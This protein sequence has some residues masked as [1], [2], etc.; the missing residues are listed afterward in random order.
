MTIIQVF[1]S[2]KTLEE[3]KLLSTE[4]LQAN[5]I[6]AKSE[7]FQNHTDSF[8]I[9]DI[10]HVLQVT[11]SGVIA[12]VQVIQLILNLQDRKNNSQK[13][14]VAI[15]IKASNGKS[16]DLKAS[17]DLTD[18]ETKKYLNDI[19]SFVDDFL[20]G[21]DGV[22]LRMPSEGGLLSV[23]VC[24]ANQLFRELDDKLS[25]IRELKCSY[26]RISDSSVVAKLTFAQ[27]SLIEFIMG[28]KEKK[29][30]LNYS[31]AIECQDIF[32][33]LER[34]NVLAFQEISYDCKAD[35]DDLSITLVRYEVNQSPLFEQLMRCEDFVFS[36]L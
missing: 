28:S 32:Y 26:H 11:F 5:E 19:R 14:S 27:I 30:Y 33:I 36:Y 1:G 35:I 24:A 7:I 3:I 15:N 22:C 31:E 25:D 10:T 20:T 2:R 23:N 9:E 34:E 18:L 16:L 6:Q 8:D 29:V 13:N 21:D 17:G 4:I 12:L